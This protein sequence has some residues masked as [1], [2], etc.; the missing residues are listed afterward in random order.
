MPATTRQQTRKNNHYETARPK[1]ISKRITKPRPNMKK[2][3]APESDK[4]SKK[5]ATEE[6]PIYDELGYELD[7]EKIAKAKK[8]TLKRRSPEAYMKMINQQLKEQNR[9]ADI[10]GTPN[11]KVSGITLMAWDNRVGRELG[12]PYHKVCMGDYEEISRRGI[13]FKRGEFLHENISPE[14]RDWLMTLTTGGDFRI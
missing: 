14:K 4:P 2:L 9:K 13:K 6:V 7:P 1:P 12:K 11:D 10:M 5:A 3:R 8:R